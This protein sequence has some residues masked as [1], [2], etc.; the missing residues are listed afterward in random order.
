M[1]NTETGFAFIRYQVL[2][3]ATIP[4]HQIASRIAKTIDDNNKQELDDPLVKAKLA[5]QN[6]NHASIIVHYTHENRFESTKR[7]IHQIW[8]QK[9]QQ[10]PVLNTRLII[11]NLNSH[12]ITRELVHRSPHS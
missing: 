1:I 11:G 4:E 7:D 3:K 8:N 5:K 2:I 6:K 9:F 12:N 10:T